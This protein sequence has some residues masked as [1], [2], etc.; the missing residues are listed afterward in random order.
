MGETDFEKDLDK[1]KTIIF[2]IHIDGHMSILI[3]HK[4]QARSKEGKMDGQWIITSYDSS[5]IVQDELVKIFTE[6]MEKKLNRKVIEVGKLGETVLLRPTYEPSPFRTRFDYSED[7]QVDD[8]GSSEYIR[9]LLPISASPF[10]L[11]K[12]FKK[13]LSEGMPPGVRSSL[14]RLDQGQAVGF[15]TSG[16]EIRDSVSAIKAFV[17]EIVNGVYFWNLDHGTEPSM[18]AADAFHIENLFRRDRFMAQDSAWAIRPEG[19]NTHTLDDRYSDGRCFWWTIYFMTYSALLAPVYP[20]FYKMSPPEI[21]IREFMHFVVDI[22]KHFQRDSL[23]GLGKWGRKKF[24]QFKIPVISSSKRKK[25]KGGAMINE[26]KPASK[27]VIKLFEKMQELFAKWVKDNTKPLTKDE[28]DIFER[29]MFNLY[30][31]NGKEKADKIIA[32]RNDEEE[33]K[34][35][36]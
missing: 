14:N 32:E 3:L 16:E 24:K 12:S 4:S 29:D 8:A 2:P 9:D 15:T 26:I 28:E 34:D 33:T 10:D 20:D 13:F 7:M 17:D 19:Y 21:N 23:V 35:K 36:I 25:M 5:N 31:T 6:K 18:F 22:V 27:E 1:R 30:E 11:L